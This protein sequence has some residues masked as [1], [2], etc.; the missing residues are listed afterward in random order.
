MIVLVPVYQPGK[1]LL[2]LV[3]DLADAGWDGP[4]V[5]VDDGSGPGATAV[6]AAARERGCT[7]LRRRVN[8]GKGVVLKTGF[9]YVASHHPGRDVVCVD[10]DGQHRAGDVR[11][12]AQRMRDTG[13]LTLGVRRFAGDVPLRSRF[14]NA[15]TREAFHLA[16]GCPLRDT[17]TGLRAY[18]ARLLDRL[19]A[20]PG[21]RF[22]YEMNVL[23]HAVRDGWPI[24]QVEIPTRYRGGNSASH[25][26]AL[27]DSA[28]I[29]AALAGFAATRPLAG[30]RS[31]GPGPSTGAPPA[32]ADRPA[33]R[34]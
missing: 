13:A 16:T 12:V 1:D 28:R 24:E 31:S 32:P 22:E 21:S 33:A 4:P 15:V 10:A 25:F 29:Y 5:V 23:L 27:V 9:R 26:S 6:L 14:G 7:V 30:A 18:P 20:I 8:R 34:R 11:L 2:R 19:A 3:D 17:Q